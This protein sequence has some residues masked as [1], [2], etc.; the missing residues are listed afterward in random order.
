MMYLRRVSLPGDAS[1]VP[2]QQIVELKIGDN[3]RIISSPYI[4]IQ[5]KV[6]VIDQTAT[7]LPSG[8]TVPMVTVDTKSKKIKVPYLNIEVLR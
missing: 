6:V 7:K 2:E 5:G 3:I 1:E 4:G 8:I